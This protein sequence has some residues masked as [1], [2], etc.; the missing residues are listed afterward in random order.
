[1]NALKKLESV[2]VRV[3]S[4]L[5]VAFLTIMV[6][7]SFSQVVLRQAFSTGLLWAD[8]FLRHLVLWVGF[9][10][11]ALAS[12]DNKHFAWDTGVMFL[13]G[14]TKKA[15]VALSHLCACAITVILAQASWHFLLEEKASNTPLFTVGTLVVPAWWFSVIL[16]VG[17]GLVGLHMLLKAALEFHE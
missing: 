13:T 4:A 12:A 14:K 10:G 3:E 2:L 16:P 15:V 1:L 6:A 9:L 11:A 17:F 7:L 8:T 5:L